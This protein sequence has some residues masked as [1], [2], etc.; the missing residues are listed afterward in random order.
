MNRPLASLAV[1]SSIVALVVACRPAS[2][3][4]AGDRDP[5]W[6]AEVTRACALQASCAHGHQSNEKRDPGKCI[7]AWVAEMGTKSDGEGGP[8]ARQVCM[9]HAKTCEAA[10]ACEAPAD[11][12]AAAFCASHHETATSC[13]GNA[14]VE[15]GDDADEAERVDCATVQGTCELVKHSGGLT[16]SACVS[17]ALCPAGAKEGRCEAGGTVLTC[18]DGAAERIACKRGQRCVARKDD[19]GIERASCEAEGAPRCSAPGARYCEGERLV[20]CMG[21]RGNEKGAVEVTDCGALGLRCEGQGKTAGCYV[22]GKPD[23]SIDDA[24]V[25]DA[26]VMA[27]CALGRKVEVT[28][29]AVGAAQCEGGSIPVCQPSAATGAPPAHGH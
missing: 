21:P 25:C 3:P 18:Q 24:P 29:A 16:E 10:H 19:D 14:R 6:F 8:S 28:C 20:S 1:V 5:S 17:R 9:M 7:T 11:R 13:D 4:P 23:C 2:P 15:C 22:L 27:Y 12:A 26:G